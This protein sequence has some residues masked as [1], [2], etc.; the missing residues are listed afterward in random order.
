[1]DKLARP[2]VGE[3]AEGSEAAPRQQKLG[4]ERRGWVAEELF[5]ITRASA[6]V[7]ECRNAICRETTE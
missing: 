3:T 6:K 7:G 2:E 1:M 4:G 5:A